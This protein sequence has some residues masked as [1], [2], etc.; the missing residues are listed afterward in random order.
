MNYPITASCQCGQVSY[1]LNKAP[2]KVLACHCKECQTLSSSPF[3]VTA[4]V[5]SSDITFD[6]D[7]KQWSRIADSGN[8]NHAKFCPTC[9]TRIYHYNPDMPDLIKLKLKPVGASIDTDFAPTLH[10]WVSEKQS[11]YQIPTGIEALAKQ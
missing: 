11:W 6:G 2:N 10:V 9:G 5:P 3:S 4:V 7:M 1:T 8:Q